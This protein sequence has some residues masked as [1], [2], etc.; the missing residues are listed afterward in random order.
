MKKTLLLAALACWS[1]GIIKDI[2][3]KTITLVLFLMVMVLFSS[4]STTESG[5]SVGEVKNSEC[6]QETRAT[7]EL[8]PHPQLKMTRSGSS[9]SCELLDYP[10]NCHHGDLYVDGRQEGNSLDIRVR[11]KKADGEAIMT[12]CLCWINLYFTMYDVEGD[13]FV[14]MLDGKDL[15]EVSFKGRSSVEIDL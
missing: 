7:D 2:R 5:L 11:E 3:I 4:C 14:L 8:L 13:T 12:T 9:I 1:V 6:V 10:V 15:G